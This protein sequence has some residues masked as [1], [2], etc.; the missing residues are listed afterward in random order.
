[1]LVLPVLNYSFVRDFKN[2][3]HKAWHRYVLKDTV[4]TST[5]AMDQ[6]REDHDALAARIKRGTA[7][8]RH[9]RHADKLCAV[10][11]ALPDTVRV[12]VEWFGGIRADGSPCA[13]DDQKCWFR[14]KPDVAVITPAGSWLVD[15]KTGRRWEDPFE[16]GTQAM[17]LSAHHPESRIWQGEYYWLA[18]EVPGDRYSLS[19]GDAFMNL[20]RDHETMLRYQESDQWPKKPNKIC[21]WCNCTSCEHNPNVK[22]KH[23]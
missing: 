2:C 17:M 22:T 3:P 15:W 6:G 11:D 7:L 23:D 10:F 20:K 1:M 16:L 21:N 19:P 5:S 4:F 18:D 9:L 14:T 13:W 12:K 8:P